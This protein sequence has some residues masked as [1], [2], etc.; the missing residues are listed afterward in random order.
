MTE[1]L[2]AQYLAQLRAGLRTPPER[3]EQILAEAEDHLRESAAAGEATG[4]TERAAQEAALAAFGQVGAVVRAHRRPAA[5]L[6]AEIGM[7]AMKLAAVYLLT[8]PAAGLAAAILNKVL[9]QLAAPAGVKFVAAPAGYSYSR[10]IVVLAV[11][12]AAGLALLAVYRRARYRRTRGTR[13]RGDREPAAL[14]GGYFPLAAVIC[15]LILVLFV[16]PMLR[17][18][19]VPGAT[20]AAAP[21]LSAVVTFGAFA[22][23][24]GYAVRMAWILLR[25]RETGA[26][27]GERVPHAG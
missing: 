24:V 5:A 27:A 26:E 25:Q 16:I 12:A 21:G 17:A 18:V 3:T 6:L 4:L 8:M 20:F 14:L 23:A 15:T 22:V 19:R 2:I 7:A 10:T 13:R 1:D 11:S 9:L